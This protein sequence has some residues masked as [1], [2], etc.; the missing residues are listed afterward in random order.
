MNK[1]LERHKA[2]REKNRQ[3]IRRLEAR[4]AE[5]D[6]LIQAE[7]NSEI[8]ALVHNA[9]LDSFGLAEL[10]AKLQENNGVPIHIENAEDDAYEE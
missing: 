1:K 8:V 10:L 9:N 3:R 5:L 6:E 4:N 2:E 7:E